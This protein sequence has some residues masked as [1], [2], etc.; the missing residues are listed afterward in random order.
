MNNTWEKL[1]SYSLF[2]HRDNY[3]HCTFF[4]P[5]WLS[6]AVVMSRWI[7]QDSGR[8]EKGGNAEIYK[9]RI[10]IEGIITHSI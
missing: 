2:Q 6:I 10:I 5:L 1:Q 8:E 4:C 9:E 7:Q 3:L